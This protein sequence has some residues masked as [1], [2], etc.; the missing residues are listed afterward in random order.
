MSP[1]F[2][3]RSR[4]TTGPLDAGVYPRSGRLTPAEWFSDEWRTIITAR[5]NV[6]I[7]GPEA[8]AEACI[9]VWTPTL[10]TPVAAWEDGP[11][12]ERPA[13]LLIRRVGALARDD[14][15]RLLRWLEL[16]GETPQVIATTDKPL[17]PFA[18]MNGFQPELYYRLN[19]IRLDLLKPRAHGVS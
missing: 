17:F 12:G 8:M 7:E 4:P 1:D 15:Q 6:L 3:W 11:P 10:R 2:L 9:L 19:V 14:Q 18:G 16:P 5:P 13:T